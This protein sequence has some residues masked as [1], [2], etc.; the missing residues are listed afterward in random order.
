MK[1][2]KDPIN[3][4]SR[5]SLLIDFLKQEGF[6]THT[7]KEEGSII[8]LSLI[9]KIKSDTDLQ[10]VLDR[11]VAISGDIY[12]DKRF[13]GVRC[14]NVPLSKLNKIYQDKDNNNTQSE[15]PKHITTEIKKNSEFFQHRICFHP[16]ETID[17][18]PS[19]NDD[20]ALW[21]ESEVYSYNEDL[22][23][24]LN[25]NN[26]QFNNQNNSNY[27]TSTMKFLRLMER[28]WSIILYGAPEP[29]K[30]ISG[31]KLLKDS[32]LGSI[33]SS[34]TK[35]K[36]NHKMHNGNGNEE[37]NK[38]SSTNNISSIFNNI[39]E[40]TLLN[41]KTTQRTIYRS[42]IKGDSFN[43]IDM[44]GYK[45]KFE[46]TRRGY[47]FKINVKNHYLNNLNLKS[48]SL[49]GN[50]NSNNGND[51][52][53][54]NDD[55]NYNNDIDDNLDSNN[56]KL[57]DTISN[58]NKKDNNNNNSSNP[59]S[60]SNSIKD[61]LNNNLNNLNDEYIEIE[62]YKIQYLKNQFKVT[63]GYDLNKLDINLFSMIDK[64]LENN[65]QP[66]SKD[67]LNYPN[68]YINLL[69]EYNNP[70]WLI[71]IK[72][73]TKNIN[74]VS[75]GML[76]LNNLSNNLSGIVELRSINHNLLKSKIY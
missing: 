54:N 67:K 8:Q 25:N 39:N 71:E 1:D 18:G 62:I 40:D 42:L 29:L 26:K 46:Y 66:Q 3:E 72:Y 4:F 60:N 69:N 23:D 49:T 20:V 21:M 59:I 73:E 22:N 50:K 12:F 28:D 33:E 52:S 68:G 56:N 57:K 35:E 15:I 63:S 6:S 48:G 58:K 14:R 16:I 19:R 70:I 53:N 11:L 32:M 37:S 47:K 9:G 61:Y 76:E 64:E 75:H 44:L 74:S 41:N 38:N 2:S 24:I 5:S 51:N 43:L 55:S 31:S 36:L 17:Y 34:N 10:F 7:S 65:N 27:S 13:G 45:F 30:D